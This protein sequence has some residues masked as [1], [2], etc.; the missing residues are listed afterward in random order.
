MAVLQSHEAPAVGQQIICIFNNT[1]SFVRK[2]KYDGTLQVTTQKW[3]KDREGWEMGLWH[4]FDFKISM[5]WT[6]INM[7]SLLQ[8]KEN[9]IS[10][11]TL[12][13]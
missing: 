7:C 1:I 4:D 8:D 6:I 2:Y 12:F 5:E 10:N 11:M 3:I 9:Y 13:V